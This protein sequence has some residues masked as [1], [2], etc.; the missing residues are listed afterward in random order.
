MRDDGVRGDDAAE[1]GAGVALYLF[2]KKGSWVG[3]AVAAK[4]A[5][6][7]DDGP[8]LSSPC[9]YPLALVSNGD[10]ALIETE[11]SQTASS[12]KIDAIAD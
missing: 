11:V 2:A 10:W 12:A 9:L 7:T 8:E 3:N 5:A 4:T 6:I 1:V